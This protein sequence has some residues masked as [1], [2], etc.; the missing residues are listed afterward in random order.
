MKGRLDLHGL[1]VCPPGQ[2]EV[3]AVLEQGVKLQAHQPALGQHIPPL[4]H[5]GAEVIL[6]GRVSQHQCLPEQGPALGPADVKGICQPGQ[7][8]QGHVAALAGKPIAQSG[9]IQK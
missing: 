5:A 6:Q 2:V 8:S 7:V 1:A 9:P 3:Q 4:L